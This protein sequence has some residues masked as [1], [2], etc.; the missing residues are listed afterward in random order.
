MD[1]K[2]KLMVQDIYIG[3]PDAKD[4]IISQK[5]D[6]FLRSFVIP[7]N[8]EFDELINKDKIFISGYKGTGKTALLLFLDAECKKRDNQTCSSF[9]LFKTQYGNIQRL[10][11][12]KISKNIIK[13]IDVA[14]DA[15]KNEQDFEYIWR[16]IFLKQ[17][18][19]DNSTYN[20][21][22]FVEDDNWFAFCSLVERILSEK[23]SNK[24]FKIPNKVKFGV[25]Y[26][27][28]VSGAQTIKPEIILDFNDKENLK[29]YTQFISLIDS[30]TNALTKLK[31]KD[32]PYYLFIDELEAFYAES[33][34]LQRD[35]RMIRDLIITIKF[36]N[37]IFKTSHFQNTK[38]ICSIRTE[39]VNSICQF[40]P[41]KEI[42][43][44]VSGYACPL[45]WSYS[46]TN[47][48]AHP[49][50]E[51]WLK[52]IELSEDDIGNNYDNYKDIYDKWF[53]PEVDDHAHCYIYS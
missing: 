21:G 1:N 37:D 6:E 22:I 5:S 43:K 36:F 48:Y 14:Q 33:S 26:T 47:S 11:L 19:E 53:C 13:T 44:I 17:I 18:I 32:I 49:I 40:I 52:R 41:P 15:L 23:S 20:S 46:N 29:E 38:F 10:G 25:E 39:I 27:G 34:T 4:E 45:M 51:I 2:K 7:P 50:F 35:L 28:D 16:W 8:F 12:E 42:N 24:F 3:K 30:A 31:R 9:M